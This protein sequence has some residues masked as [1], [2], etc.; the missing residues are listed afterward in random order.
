MKRTSIL[1]ITAMVFF[2]SLVLIAEDKKTNELLE[3]ALT[4][5]T[6]QGDLAGAITLY[7]QAVKEA[8]SNRALSAKAQL[9]LAAAY[10]KQG[11]EKARAIYERIAQEYADQTDA[12]AEAHAHLASPGTL[13]GNKITEFPAKM[14]ANTLG[15]PSGR[16]I[17]LFDRSGKQLA[18]VGDPG[19][20]G[21]MA[22]SPDGKR[23]A[24]V[25]DDVIR[26]YDVKTQEFIRLTSDPFDNQPTWSSDGNRIAYEARVTRAGEGRRAGIYVVSSDGKGS[27]EFIAPVSGITLVGWSHDG[28]FLTYQQNGNGTGNDV[29]VLPL[30]G[31]RKPYPFLA[32]Q[33]SEMGLRISPDGH[34]ASYRMTEGSRT[35]VYVSPFNPDVIP[36]PTRPVEKWKI[37]VNAGVATAGVRWRA[38]GKELYFIDVNGGVNAVEITTTPNFKAGT[39][40]VLFQVPQS[41]QNA[42]ST[43]AGFSDVTADG[44]IF[45]LMVPRG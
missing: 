45:A 13:I 1:A 31:D 17:T 10:Q 34:F 22:I 40:K 5:E 19:P 36:D 3:A 15:T 37:S 25:R 27:D 28:R 11:D 24:L 14:I 30:A 32:T 41:Y 33:A 6:I 2:A 43:T 9:R 12:A 16:Q 29:W 8:G 20:P 4:K 38:D 35:D 26:V 44:K 23:V 42:S 21:T 7:E 39:P 18:T